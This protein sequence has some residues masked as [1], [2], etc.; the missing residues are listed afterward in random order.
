MFLSTLAFSHS[1]SRAAAIR[2]AEREAVS[3]AAG[4]IRGIE[5]VL[6]SVE[7][8]TRLVGAALDADDAS[9]VRA[10]ALLRGF[11]STHPD[12]FGSAV[13]FAP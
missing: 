3:E 10:E 9:A 6:R 5:A 13:A 4:A 1:R 11:L 12:V 8:S 2:A 7:R